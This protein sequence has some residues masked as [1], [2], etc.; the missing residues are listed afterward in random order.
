MKRRKRNRM[1]GF[2]Y[3]SNR[4]YFITNCVKNNRCCFGQVVAIG[5]GRDLSVADA[6]PENNSL[7][8]INPHIGYQ[9]QLNVYGLIVEE[10][11]KWLAMQYPYVVIHNYK[12][13]PNHIHLILEIDS[14]K[15]DSSEIK[16]KSVSELMGA[17]KTT[18][19]KYIKQAGLIDFSWHRS[20]HDHIIRNFISFVRISKYIDLNPQKWYHDKF[21]NA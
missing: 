19:S 12:V 4:L 9:M 2:D 21:F 7:P 17:F 14:K 15:V 13:M 1:Q 10:R 20:F 18:S 5:T 16:I 11:I 6:L 3:S 8:K